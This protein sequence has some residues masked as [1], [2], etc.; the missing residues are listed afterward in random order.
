MSIKQGERIK[1]PR[2]FPF[3][4][5][6][7]KFNPLPRARLVTINC[8]SSSNYLYFTT[9]KAK[10]ED[11]EREGLVDWDVEGLSVTDKGKG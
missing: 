2:G 10:M 3:C 4:N 7:N 6:G 5:Y 9:G 11:L 1:L 8:A